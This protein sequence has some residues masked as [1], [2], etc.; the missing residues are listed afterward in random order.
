MCNIVTPVFNF[1]QQATLKS[2]RFKN[3]SFSSAG[4]DASG[5]N[6]VSIQMSGV[7]TDWET[8]ASQADEF[9]KPDYK[10]IVSEPKITNLS[11]NADGTISF[12]FSA[13][14]SPDFLVYANNATLNN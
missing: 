4:K 9:G 5:A 3:F 14:I 8:V 1:L 7:A 2:V 10:K 11:L 13:F 12:L 6:R